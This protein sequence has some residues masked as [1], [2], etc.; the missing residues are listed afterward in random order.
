[1]TDSVRRAKPLPLPVKLVFAMTGLWGFVTILPIMPY[2]TV[3]RG[4]SWGA[5]TPP[6]PVFAPILVADPVIRSQF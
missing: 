1:M 4:F 5:G 2:E 6:P 3:C